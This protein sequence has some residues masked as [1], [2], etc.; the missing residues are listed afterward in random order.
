MTG[1]CCPGILLDGKGVQGLE[2]ADKNNNIERWQER[3]IIG[4]NSLHKPSSQTLHQAIEATA[5][6]LAEK[7]ALIDQ[8]QS[9]SFF[10][11]N[12][13]ANQLARGLSDNGV[14][15][16]D[17]VGIY[18][19][20]SVCGMVALLAVLKL[21]AVYVPLERSLPAGRIKTI[22]HEAMLSL[23]ICQQCDL[24]LMQS[25]A[26]KVCNIND[27]Q[28]LTR[29]ADSN[30]NTKVS[31]QQTAYI[32]FTSGSSGKPKGVAVSHYSVMALLQSMLGV[33]G[34]Q[35]DECWLG[36]ASW[37]FDTSVVENFFPLVFGGTL[38]MAQKDWIFDSQKIQQMIQ[39][40]QITLVQQT[41]SV[42]RWL[43]S[44][45]WYCDRNI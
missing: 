27:Q 45:G 13:K 6:L 10:V 36:L 3:G 32:M 4:D 29:H 38:V 22:V 14:K 2:M 31:N 7:T 21:G 39:Q 25:I 17:R 26:P 43:M 35:G 11:L 42:W 18:I 41:P 34:I 23:I 16:D 37:A 8:C 15:T 9:M 5:L 20:R 19:D 30:L 44:A 1:G 28:A 12:S 40:Y 24:P 33:D